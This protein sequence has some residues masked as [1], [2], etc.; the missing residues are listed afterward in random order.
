MVLVDESNESQKV[1]TVKK[2]LINTGIFNF[3]F[4]FN[5]KPHGSICG[6]INC[7]IHTPYL[8]EIKV[9]VA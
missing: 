3:F 5:N 2:I 9:N 6:I 8:G 7:T 1:K 4:K